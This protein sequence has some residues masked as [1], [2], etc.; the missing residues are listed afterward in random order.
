MDKV[1][2]GVKS[3]R[4]GEKQLI[5]LLKSGFGLV[6]LLRSEFKCH[7]NELV[8]SNSIV[9]LSGD[10]D[11][12]WGSLAYQVSDTLSKYYSFMIPYDLFSALQQ[13]FKMDLMD[14]VKRIPSDSQLS[15]V[16]PLTNDITIW[17]FWNNIQIKNVSVMLYVGGEVDTEIVSR[18]STEP[19]SSLMLST[20]NFL[21]G[22]EI[23]ELTCYLQKTLKML[24][25]KTPPA[26]ILSTESE[27]V[28]YLKTLKTYISKI[29]ID[30]TYDILIDPLQPLKDNLTLEVYEVFERDKTKYEQY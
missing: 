6:L 7:T 29:Q 18:W 4:H 3:D 8:L 10:A 13:R 9:L 26:I 23:P 24:V 2:Y 16:V 15:L 17:E 25:K 1:Y 12:F 14:F 19:I 21:Q 5:K 22:D 20:A 11:N 30:P 28:A 27:Q